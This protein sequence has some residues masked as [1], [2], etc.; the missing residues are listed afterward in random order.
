MN[1][2]EK[3]TSCADTKEEMRVMVKRCLSLLL[4]VVTA[5]SLS[6]AAFAAEDGEDPPSWRSRPRWKNPP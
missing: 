2:Y 1:V 4:A 5:F 3:E 6:A